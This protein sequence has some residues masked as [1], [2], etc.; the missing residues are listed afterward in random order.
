MNET[1]TVPF[2][3][4]LPDRR[5]RR[6]Y[7]MGIWRLC[8]RLLCRRAQCCR[9]DPD[10]CLARYMKIVPEKARLFLAG[11]EAAV[12]HYGVPFDQAV[13]DLH[14]EAAAYKA[15][16][17]ALDAMERKPRRQPQGGGA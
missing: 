8:G 15:W 1:T 10:D 5:Q 3:Q 2:H 7:R 12:N 11:L 16:L 9:G 14:E 17:D 4:R 6:I 13:E